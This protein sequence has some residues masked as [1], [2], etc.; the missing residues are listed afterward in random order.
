[1]RILFLTRLHPLKK[2]GTPLESRLHDRLTELSELG[3]DVLVLTRWTGEPVDFE[4]PSRIEIRSPFKTFRPWEWP[5]AL[6]MV[7]AWRPD[8]LHV[9][10]PGLSKLDRTLSVEMMAMT[11]LETLSRASRGRS[12]FRGSLISVSG[13]VKGDSH[14]GWKRAG[15]KMTEDAWLRPVGAEKSVRPWDQALGRPLRVALA[16]QI[17]RE[18]SLDD[19]LEAL[20]IMRELDDVE[21]TVFLDRSSLSTHDR[22]RLAHGERQTLRNSESSVGSRLHLSQIDLNSTTPLDFDVAI[23]AGLEVSVA[24]TW[25][26]RCAMPVVLSESHSSLLRELERSGMTSQVLGTPVTEIAAI[27]QSLKTAADRYFLSES[28]EKLENGALAG[29][30]DVA[31]NQLSRIYS[32]IAGTSSTSYS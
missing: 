27:A 13:M 16:G 7:F 1:M 23:V 18:R 11:M 9:F 25:I 6:P 29:G 26:E 31:A 32:Q 14:S 21:L 4:L 20:A 15:A 8:L 5:A 2:L 17:G 28:W 30:R 24:R 22:R 19:V 10:D 3:H 12:S